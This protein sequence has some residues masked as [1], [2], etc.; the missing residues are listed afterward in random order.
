MT[1]SLN[2]LVLNKINLQD[3]P[4]QRTTMK[5]DI[6]RLLE[7]RKKH[8]Y[9]QQQIADMMGM[10]YSTY[11]K[12][13]SGEIKVDIEKGLKLAKIYGVTLDTLFGK[14]AEGAQKNIEAS[15][16]IIEKKKPF[17]LMIEIDTDSTTEGKLPVFIQKLQKL[18]EEENENN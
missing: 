18:I 1:I 11:G 5:V 3:Q 15:P 6:S 8:G 16:R 14:Q 10:H 13:E 12:M 2:N 4:I 9:T 17:K 7:Y